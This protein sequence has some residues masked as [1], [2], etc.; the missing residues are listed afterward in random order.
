MAYNWGEL[1]AKLGGARAGD[2]ALEWLNR[3]EL[4]GTEMNANA[5]EQVPDVD[6]ER[7]RDVDVASLRSNS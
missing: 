3:S 2:K 6:V 4:K 1:M 7:V 5:V